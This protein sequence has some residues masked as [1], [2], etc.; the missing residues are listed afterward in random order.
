MAAVR[1]H[2]QFGRNPCL[3]QLLIESDRRCRATGIAA[4]CDQEGGRGGGHR[5][6]GY[7]AWAGKDEDLKVGACRLTIDHVHHGAPRG[8]GIVRDKRDELA[9]GRKAHGTDPGGI[10]AVLNGV[11]THPAQRAAC[12]VRRVALDGVGRSGFVRQPVFQHE[13]GH[14][15]P[16]ERD[17]DFRALVGPDEQ[18]VPA[19]RYHDHGGTVAVRRRRWKRDQRRVVNVAHPVIAS[20]LRLAAARGRAGCAVRP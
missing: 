19:A 7:A 8:L 16:V 13:R 10:D 18:L 15:H 17:R 12:I 14:A 4:A 5:G 20:D 3:A 6:R 1:I 11:R 9:T 2:V